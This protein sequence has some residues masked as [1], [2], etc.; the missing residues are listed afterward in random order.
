[1]ELA[2]SKKEQLKTILQSLESVDFSGES[3]FAFKKADELDEFV[4]ANE[5][6]VIDFTKSLLNA[7]IA[8]EGQYGELDYDVLAIGSDMKPTYV[9]FNNRET[10]SVKAKKAEPF[11]LKKLVCFGLYVLTVTVSLVCLAAGAFTIVS[12][13]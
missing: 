10:T 13:F 12:Q 9:E 6:G 1:M 5:K 11:G 3:Y 4:Q 7:V 8:K 2:V